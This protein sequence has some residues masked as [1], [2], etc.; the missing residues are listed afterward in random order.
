ML[1]HDNGLRHL[2]QEVRSA[3]VGPLRLRRLLLS[4][5]AEFD[6]P[7]LVVVPQQPQQLISVVPKPLVLLLQKL[8]LRGCRFER[9]HQQQRSLQ[10]PTSDQVAQRRLGHRAGP[11]VPRECTV[12]QQLVECALRVSQRLPVLVQQRFDRAALEKR[13]APQ[14]LQPFAFDVVDPRLLDMQKPRDARS[15][16]RAALDTLPRFLLAFGAQRPAA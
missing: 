10:P 5:L 6:R 11:R 15:S 2:S 16:G 12:A 1:I 9:H 13:L 3:V 4:V 8:R 7:G 14:R